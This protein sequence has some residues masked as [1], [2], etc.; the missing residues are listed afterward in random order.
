M[1]IF[2]V[3]EFQ[4]LACVI[5]FLQLVFEKLL[6]YLEIEIECLNEKIDF[7]KG[8]ESVM[9]LKFDAIFTPMTGALPQNRSVSELISIL[10]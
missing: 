1:L 4:S 3:F 10:S 9:V 6:W 8:D 7:Y 2:L 5:I